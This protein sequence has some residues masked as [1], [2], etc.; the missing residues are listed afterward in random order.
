MSKLKVFA[1]MGREWI[2]AKLTLAI[3]LMLG[4]AFMVSG[5][6]QLQNTLVALF[7]VSSVSLYESIVPGG[8]ALDRGLKPWILAAFEI[9]WLI[10][11]IAAALITVQMKSWRGM[12]I[13]ISA[14]VALVLTVLDI[15]F[16]TIDYVMTIDDLVTNISANILGGLSIGA[17]LFLI[18]WMSLFVCKAIGAGQEHQGIVT[19]TVATILGLVISLVL[20]VTMATVSQ[21]MK[22]KAR[23]LAKL[24]TKGVIGK[25]YTK[26]E[27]EEDENRFQSLSQV[28][29][30][31][32]VGLRGANGLEWDWMRVDEGARYSISVYAVTGCSELDQAQELTKG[33]PIIEIGGVDRVRIAA[34]DFINQFVLEGQQTGVSVE[35]E[36]VSLFWLNKNDSGKDVDLTEFLPDGTT[37]SG[38]TQGDMALLA[39]AM[40]FQEVEGAEVT[41]QSPRT[42]Y[43]QINNEKIRPIMF[44]P[45]MFVPPLT[46]DNLICKS[47]DLV[48]DPMR[49]IRYD[50][51]AL[52]GLYA[53]IKRVQ[54]L[55][56][57]SDNIGGK[58][59]FRKAKG[60][61][62][63]Q[64][65]LHGDVLS[66]AEE[67][68]G[69]I[70]IQTPIHEI[71]VNGEPYE[72][73]T[74]AGFRGHGK[75]IRVSYDEASGLTFSGDFHAAWMDERRLNLTRWERWTFNTKRGIL[76]IIVSVVGGVVTLI[77]R[78]RNT[79]IAFV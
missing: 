76:I 27:D 79:W 15:V 17:A 53:E 60:F 40:T 70:V 65:D 57:Y 35:R 21:P 2:R 51:V 3:G 34:D 22:V 45:I 36:T 50:N 32:R 77:Y 52:A 61:F 23:I 6:P 9:P 63:R 56:Y 55:G 46:D 67:K 16:G 37:I 62:R 10:T 54:P 12:V 73:P 28:T 59:T 4:I 42:F 49:E 64:N 74:D 8:I 72:V 14:T 13:A 33:E 41:Q 71:F 19:G 58:Y 29:K 25:T 24:P 68:L 1:L 18:L 66:V 11:G 44:G 75:Y 31:A 26:V 69:M 38:D 47:L 20:Y 7:D 43:L 5:G 78:T 30:V 39:T 48:S